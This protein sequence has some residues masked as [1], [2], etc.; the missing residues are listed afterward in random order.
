MPNYHKVENYQY[1]GTSKQNKK[2]NTT[3]DIKNEKKNE[4]CKGSSELKKK[5]HLQK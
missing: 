4:S 2:S 1:S 3:R 5:T